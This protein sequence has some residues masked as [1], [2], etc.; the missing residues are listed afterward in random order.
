ME[1]QL[2]LPRNDNQQAFIDYLNATLRV[3]SS[4]YRGSA[5]VAADG[6]FYSTMSGPCR[7]EDH[8]LELR[9]S[10]IRDQEGRLQRLVVE[11][12][13]ETMKDRDWERVVHSF[14]NSVLAATLAGSRQ[15][16]FR[17]AL[18]YYIGA[19]LDGEYWLPG[20]RFA[21]AHPSDPHPYLISAERV[22]VID[23]SVNAVD[24]SHA[25]ALSQEAAQRHAARLSLLLNTGLY[26]L[27]QVHRWVLPTVDNVPAAESVRYQMGFFHPALQLNAMPRR[28]ELCEL[29]QYRGHLAAHVRYAGEKLSLPAEARRI[30]RG[31][32]A[33]PPAITDAF[34]RAARL[35]QVATIC[36]R[37]FPSVAMAY[38]VASIESISKR[39]PNRCGFSEFMRRYVRPDRDISKELE[40]LYGVARSAHFH[41]GVFPMGE[42]ARPE[43]MINPFMDAESVQREEFHRSCRAL[44]REAL[45]NWIV[46]LVPEVNSGAGEEGQ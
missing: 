2:Q 40:Y 13:D 5:G 28:E 32:D 43:G 6:S 30:L 36:G 21:P 29:G 31:I 9:W 38:R 35:Y 8:D 34:D 26:G 4:A 14:I 11:N 27:Q 10:L 15:H 42:F 46:S 44:T 25:W 22:V 7:L 12:L 16:F 39:G 1:I 37:Y 18:F 17:R 3:R 45:V 41:G 19:Q 24:A 33:A 23:Q 20:F